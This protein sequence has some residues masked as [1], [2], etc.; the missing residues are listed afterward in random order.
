MKILP[1]LTQTSNNKTPLP[2]IDQ[3]G[4][5]P[6]VLS[7]PGTR[8][9]SFSKGNL[10]VPSPRNSIDQ[11]AVFPVSS[12]PASLVRSNT[13]LQSNNANNSG[14]SLT[15]TTNSPTPSLTSLAYASSVA[16]GNIRSTVYSTPGSMQNATDDK[17]DNNKAPGSS[18]PY[19]KDSN[20]R[21]NSN[22]TK[23]NNSSNINSSARKPLTSRMVTSQCT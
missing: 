7:T 23:L 6:P 5:Y 4:Q 10:P 14:A 9:G 19:S 8:F 15:A 21:A 16:A 3:L 11:S 1:P 2:S 13:L 20:T 22:K 12:F 17:T 18:D